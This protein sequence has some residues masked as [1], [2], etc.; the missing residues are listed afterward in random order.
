MHLRK[1]VYKT[2]SATQ[3]QTLSI[4]KERRFVSFLKFYEFEFGLRLVGCAASAATLV[5]AMTMVMVDPVAT[6]TPGTAG[7][8]RRSRGQPKLEQEQQSSV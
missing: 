3:T 2:G 6:V 5:M 8:S 7:G 1:Y 4:R